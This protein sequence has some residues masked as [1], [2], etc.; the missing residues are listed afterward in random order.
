MEEETRERET[1]RPHVDYWKKI[2]TITKTRKQVGNIWLEV[3]ISV[4]RPVFVGG[5]EGFFR[6]NAMIKVDK[7]YIRL[8]TRAFLELF[9]ILI[10]KQDAI[11]DTVDEI[12]ER[13]MQI[14]D[15]NRREFASGRRRRRRLNSSED[16]EQESEPNG[17]LKFRDD[18][19][20]APVYNR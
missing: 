18:R 5:D 4:E 11:L 2:K 10:A 8:S 3:E 16:S 17:N 14:K 19:R 1:S 20:E 15:L 12:R 13:N 6:V 9:D 7:H